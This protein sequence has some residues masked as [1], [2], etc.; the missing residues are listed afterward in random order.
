MASKR[1]F[2]EEEFS[3]PV[4]RDV[5]THPVVLTCG[6]SFCRGCIEEFWNFN[7]TR[8]CPVCRQ[9]T[10]REPSLNFT[11]RNLCQS[12]VNHRRFLEEHCEVHQ[13][14]KT[15]VCCEDEQLM[16]E[17]CRDTEKHKN[18]TYRSVQEVARERK[19][20]LRSQLDLFT[21][22]RK[23]LQDAKAELNYNSD[24]LLNK[25]NF[26]ARMITERFKHLHKLL[27]EEKNRLHDELKLEL[28]EKDQRIEEKVQQMQSDI[29][30][31]SSKIVNFRTVLECG[32]IDIVNRFKE[33]V[34]KVPQWQP[35]N[36]DSTELIDSAKYIGNINFNVWKKMRSLAHYSPVLLDRNTANSKLCIEIDLDGV[37]MRPDWTEE[38]IQR[39]QLHR[40]PERFDHCP[41]VLGSVGF[42]TGM[43]KWDV[44]VKD[45]TSWM[46]GIAIES[47]QRKATSGIPAGVWCIGREGQVLSITDPQKSQVPLCGFEMPKILRVT[48]N[49]DEGRLS[50]SDI[51]CKTVYH[52]FTHSF[53]EKVFPFFCTESC[54]PSITILPERQ[55]EDL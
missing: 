55:S 26:I 32:D 14:R 49:L 9:T 51:E 11:L 36:T 5:F 19:E 1:P 4:C 16:C 21:N 38:E 24:D 6:H 28:E 8:R 37:R 2:T 29:V 20:A 30:S 41:C 54:D 50:F 46:V 18:H 39:E 23:H 12:F 44:D 53:T 42:T 22:Q 47:V 13:L 7:K 25:A 10:E 40:N 35:Q 45:N 27:D 31:L 43:H 15:L 33:T 17:G 52:T 34:R 48:V 3:C